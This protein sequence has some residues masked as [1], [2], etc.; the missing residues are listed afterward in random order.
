MTYPRPLPVTLTLDPYPRPLLLTLTLDPY[1]YP[2]PW[3]L[4]LDP[5]FSNAAFLVVIFQLGSWLENADRH[6]EITLEGNKP[7]LVECSFFSLF[8]FFVFFFFLPF[9]IS[10]S[11]G[12]LFNFHWLIE[13]E[14]KFGRKVTE[15]GIFKWKYVSEFHIYL[16]FIYIS[17]ETRIVNW[18]LAKDSNVEISGQNRDK[19][20]NCSE[21]S[22]ITFA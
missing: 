17:L 2:Y 16:S 1:P 10:S 15:T 9:S 18:K 12:Q 5:R 19:F 4:T 3:P 6:E 20:Y 8:F 22:S 7:K 11:F 13:V 21:Q 14:L